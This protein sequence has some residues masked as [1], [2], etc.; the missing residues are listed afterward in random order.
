MVVT[1]ALRMGLTLKQESVTHSCAL[2]SVVLCGETICLT[3]VKTVKT[4]KK[5]VKIE[6]VSAMTVFKRFQ[7]S[8]RKENPLT[9]IQQV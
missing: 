1:I 5:L 9:F 2:V 6:E 3:I 4:V 7:R 8:F